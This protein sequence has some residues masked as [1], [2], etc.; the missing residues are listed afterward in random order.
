VLAVLTIS[1]S[2]IAYCSFLTPKTV[3]TTKIGHK[4]LGSESGGQ[5]NNH[6]TPAYNEKERTFI[7]HTEISTM[8]M[9]NGKKT[10]IR[11]KR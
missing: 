3:L 10:Y 8:V 4:Y 2:T 11:Q 7:Q 5:S 9:Y 6:S 1:K